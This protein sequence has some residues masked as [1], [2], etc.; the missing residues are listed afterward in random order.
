MKKLLSFLLAFVLV[1]SLVA[2]GTTKQNET[3][4]EEKSS[5]TKV[6]PKKSDKDFKGKLAGMVTDTGGVDDE[7]FNQSAWKGLQKLKNDTGAEVTYIQSDQDSDYLPNLNRLVDKNVD[8]AWG[9]GFLLAN[10]VEMAAQQS[11][12]KNFAIIDYA[13]EKTQP[14]LTGVVFKAQEP[15]YLVGYIAANTTKTNKV[16]FVGGKK[17]VIIDQFD[18]GFR[19][20]VKDAAKELGKKIEVVVQY[21]DSFSDEAKGKSIATKIFNGGADVVFHAAGGAGKG[22]IEAAKEANK[23]A[24][25]VDQDQSRLAPKNVLTSALKRVD[26]A[27]YDVTNKI[28]SGEKIGGKTLVYSSKEAAVGIPDHTDK[29]LYPKELHEKAMQKQKDIIDGKIVPP[30][31]EETW[32]KYKAN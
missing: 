28:L 30:F 2:C 32:N 18:Y 10:Q 20:G 4:K 31:N 19:A 15:S 12:D 7:S 16:G 27:I 26:V 25:G 22:V 13:Y 24:I 5:E 21:A 29:S 3:K 6:E 17:G 8:V 1:F 14:N 23:F 11:P 9:I